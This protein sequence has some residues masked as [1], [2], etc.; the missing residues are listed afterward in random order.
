[1]NTKRLNKLFARTMYS[2]VILALVFSVTGSAY[3]QEL[4]TNPFIAVS[5][6][7][8]WFMAGDFPPE[9]PVTFSVYEHQ[10]DSEPVVVLDQFSTDGT[11]FLQTQGWE[12]T[13]DLAPGN[14]VT[15]TGGGVTK[16]L[17][18]EYVT[19]DIFDPDNDFIQGKALPGGRKVDIGVGNADGEH[20]MSVFSDE[21][22]GEWIADFT[23]E[24]FEFDI[25]EDM[26]AGAHVYDDDGDVTAAHNSGPPSPPL[27]PWRDEFDGSLGD[28]W[29]WVNENPN[30][31]S[32]T[33]N[34]GFLRIYTSP[35]GTG[36]ENLLLRPVAEGDFAIETHMFFSP[37]TNF[38]FAGLVIWQDEDNF[39]QFGRAF[40]E[41]EGAPCVGN[42]IYFDYT[43]GG[44]N[45]ATSV[46]NPSE[47]YLRLERRGEMVRALFSYEGVTWVEIG[48][49]WIPP[50]FQ[51]NG[52]GLTSAQDFFTEEWD[53]PADFDYFELTE[54]WG[55]LPEG[56]HDYDGGDVP[57]WACGAG[58]WAADPDD[59]VADLAIEVNIDGT[60]LPE[61]L[62][63]GE[64]RQDLDDAG[65]CVDG[66]CSFST[67]LWGTIS[68]YEPHNVVV[69]AQDIPSGEWVQLSNSP[70]TLTCRTYDIYAY[71]A[72]T[73]ETR[74]IT[75]LRESG[76]YNPSWSPNGKFVAHDVVTGD[77]HDIYVT[78]VLT[79]KSTLLKGAK[80]GNDAAWSPNGLWIAFDRRWTDEPHLYI[81]PFTGGQRRLVRE[82]AVSPD[83]SPSGL[84][85][86]F[87]DLADGGKLKTVGLLGHLVIEVA[88]YG[89]N[90]SWSPDGKW[91]AYQRNGDIWKVRVGPLGAPLGEPIQMTSSP[92]N[93]GGPTWSADSRYIIYSSGLNA[94][95][96]LWKVPAAGGMPTWLN[97]VPEYGDYDPDGLNN[98]IAYE[99]VSSDS[100]A[101]RVWI[102]AYSYDLPVGTLA[103]GTYP[104]HFDFE[105]SIPEPGS[106]SGQGGEFVISSGA[107]VYDG[108]VL[109][110]GPFELQGVETSDGL[111]CERVEEVSHDQPMR[112]LIGW[113]PGYDVPIPMTYAEAKAH[114]NSI[115]AKAFWGDGMSNNLV[116]HEIFPLTSQVDWPAY[117]CTY[118]R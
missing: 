101:E 46:D 49:H 52:V 38:Q 108:N 83:W 85:I 25:T 17:L 6:T 91:I 104:Y 92:F 41:Y 102:A 20:W 60:S 36:G 5:L 73:G 107:P 34:P 69:Y 118:T 111:I 45:F 18:L 93:D 84:R 103:D 19:L 51:V 10:G 90:P 28:G 8:H 98:L 66:N 96:D 115:T 1:M 14:Y 110:R 74:Q 42:G 12:H 68:S 80:G 76:E 3:A 81:V 62:Y 39:L 7:S 65:V 37:D 94:D 44:T 15:A 59:R 78:N 72:V 86:V 55:F 58:G 43:G 70:K 57:D 22:S 23:A 32:L 79:Q 75:N 106:F 117:V 105:W 71:D 82:N 56:F 35:Y 21:T 2:M 54:G 89:E 48:S 50:E 11:G 26:W 77:S 31:W 13:W 53:V 99:G 64:Y 61:W 95:H 29:Y 88:E 33:E 97:G 112:F 30:E 100:Q 116:R 87:Q 27:I 109:L 16:E 4:E 114:F 9:T 63:A 113:M 40:C 24:G 67:S 47:A